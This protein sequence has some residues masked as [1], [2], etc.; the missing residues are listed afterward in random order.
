MNRIYP[1]DTIEPLKTEWAKGHRF[2]RK[3]ETRPALPN[4]E[5]LADLLSICYH[6]SL[7][8][9]EGRRI[10]FR[11]IVYRPEEFR[12]DTISSAGLHIFSER[13][14]LFERPREFSVAELRRLAPAAEFV[15]SLICVSLSKQGRWTTWGLID[16]GSNWWDFIHHEASGGRPPPDRLTISSNSPGELVFSAAGDVFFSLRTGGLYF[17]SND[18][19]FSGLVSDYLSPAKEALYLDALK[20]L[21][22]D[23][24]DEDG[25]DNDYPRRFY[26]F[27]FSRVLSNIR[28]KGHGGTLIVVRDEISHDD[29]RLTDRATLK[30]P[31]KYDHAWK[32]MVESLKL[33]RSYYDLHFKL[34]GSKDPITVEDYQRVSIIEGQ[35]EEVKEQLS[36]CLQFLASLSSVDG[37]VVVSDRLRLIG[38]GAEVIAQSPTLSTVKLALDS[39]GRKSNKTSIE[40]YG[41]RH[42]SAFRFCSSYED[43][44]AF[45]V[46]QD[47]GIKAVKRHMKDVFMWP[48]VGMTSMGM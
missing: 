26:S 3:K 42:R 23:T 2:G 8:K 24:W 12:C 44:I 32:L 14:V 16:T 18:L 25:H 47:G 33:H 4:D 13:A 30:Y 39:R 10:E 17:P 28:E 6:A 46:S 41:T 11:V 29:P 9:E 20:A 22:S 34:W 35:M 38:F 15:R 40:S 19:L 1:L 45:I 7:L 48:D 31:S 27:C 21:D 5:H 36:E 37:A 43:S